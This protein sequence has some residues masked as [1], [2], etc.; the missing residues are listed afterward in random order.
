MW[1]DVPNQAINHPS[2]AVTLAALVAVTA[3]GTIPRS[4]FIH[5][6]S[7]EAFA[8]DIA[9]LFRDSL[10]LP[11]A[12]KSANAVIDNPSSDIEKQTRRT[13]GELCYALNGLFPR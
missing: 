4:G 6:H 8:L 13:I 7:D 11:A 2:V 1:A 9:D 12:F 3:V 5:E 10:L